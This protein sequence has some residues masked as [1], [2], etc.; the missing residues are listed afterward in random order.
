LGGLGKSDPP[1]CFRGSLEKLSL[2]PISALL[3]KIYHWNIGY[4]PAVNF[5]SR[6][7]LEQNA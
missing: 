2:C 5:F 3:G 1:N 7:D 4:M 6:L